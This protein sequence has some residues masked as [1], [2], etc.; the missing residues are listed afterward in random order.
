MADNFDNESF[1]GETFLTNSWELNFS[2]TKIL[3]TCLKDLLGGFVEA[4][5]TYLFVNYFC[6]QDELSIVMHV[7]PFFK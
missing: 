5:Y 1:F 7:L 2:R 3:R 4:K 6:L